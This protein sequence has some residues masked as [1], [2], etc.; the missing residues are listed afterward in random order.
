MRL[1]DAELHAL[2]AAQFVDDL[3]TPAGLLYAQ[4]VGAT[5]AHGLI[6]RI[7]SA[8]AL[9]CPGV[10]ALFTASDIPGLNQ[11]GNVSADEVLLADTEV[12]Y[13][14]QPIALLVAESAATARR[15]AKMVK[16]DYQPLPTVFDAREADSLGMHIAP[17]QTFNSGDV[18]SVWADC[19]LVVEGTTT[20]G[21]QEHMYLETQTALAY[22]L[23]NRGLRLI[24]ATQS[25]G[26]TQRI[27]ARVLGLSMHQ[28]EVDVPRLGGGFGGKEEQA[29]PFAAMAALAAQQLQRP[30]KLTLRR[31][32]DCQLTG[33][34]HPYDA[35]FKL[36]LDAS[37]KIL[38]YQ[39]D[40]YQNAGA[41][42]DLSLAILERTLFHAGNSYFI[43]HLRASAVSCRTHLPPNTAF[44]GFGGP[45]AMFVLECAIFKAAK[46]MGIDA[47]EIQRRNLLREHQMFYYG[48]PAQRC[49]AESS[50]DTLQT[51]F[52]L[53]RR[54]WAINAFN[55]G[56]VLEKK[57]LALMPVCFGISFTA[58]F[59]NQA[60]ALVHVY[61]DGSVGVSC[62]AVEMGQ[63]V[64]RK[65]AKVA[66][67]SLGIGEQRVKV[68]STNTSRVANMS[69]TAAST[70]ADLNGQAVRMACLQI[71]LRL[72]EIAA[73]LL[74]DAGTEQLDIEHG[75]VHRQG[76]PTKIR[77]KQLVSQA[78]M[79]RTGLSA[80]AHYA[81]PNLFFDR[82]VNQGQPFAYHVYGCAAVEVALDCLRGR[83]RIKRV[84]IVHDSGQPL[85]ERVDHG[86]IEGGVVQGLGWMTLEQVVFDQN[87]RL[88]TDNLGAYKIPDMHFA[89]EIDVHFLEVADNPAGLL[90]SK[91]VGEP[92]LMYGIAGYFALVKAIQAFNPAWRPDY[93][94]PL[95]PEKV[96]LALHG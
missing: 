35:D 89:P 13:H 50:W 49:L 60:D 34:R 48:M 84:S 79:A 74:G 38:A 46:I 25:P 96:L 29:A 1:D 26:M 76:Q 3:P 85:D 45:Q 41:F 66:A 80:Q 61:T 87:G 8:E 40:F 81:T 32:E 39:V 21:A 44:R 36:G 28:V 55:A 56:H 4:P 92:P 68:E 58:T 5:I 93:C 18:D 19:A 75:R 15:A 53:S 10:I 95:T 90:H 37:G 72:L 30:V 70:G 51:R 62:G 33:K 7:D 57:A 78:Y 65:I 69:P 71:R 52:D 67:L 27:I 42:A 63:G 54:Q 64:R 2:G 16:A 88:L 9:A 91:A 43:P 14:G 82:S 22:P 77:W 47:G 11:V 17:R 86:Q 73:G 59:L 12:L 6:T 20:S 31:G 24:S 83:Y 23:E 94:A